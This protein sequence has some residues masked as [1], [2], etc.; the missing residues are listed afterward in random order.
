M[1]NPLIDPLI[2]SFESIDPLEL[3]AIDLLKI[4]RPQTGEWFPTTLDPDAK[5]QV[6]AATVE[7]VEYT[8]RCA[9]MAR[10]L[11]HLQPVPLG[12]PLAEFAL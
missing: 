9:E 11:N 10:R 7:L 12:I 2:Q 1:N 6:V 8:R 5:S 4:L 3:Q